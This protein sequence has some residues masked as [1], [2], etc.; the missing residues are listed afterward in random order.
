MLALKRLMHQG[1]IAVSSR[2]AVVS[3]QPVMDIAIDLWPAACSYDGDAF[4]EV[5]SGAKQNQARIQMNPNEKALNKII[6]MLMQDGNEDA[7]TR[8][9]N[10]YYSET[11][12]LFNRAE[13]RDGGYEEPAG[14]LR[15]L[16]HLYTAVRPMA[17]QGE[18]QEAATPEGMESRLL[19]FQRKALAW[20]LARE[21]EVSE[22]EVHPQWVEML[23]PGGETLYS[24]VVLP[25]LL[26]T[27]RF[28]APAMEAG[29]IL[30]E[31]MGLGEFPNRSLTVP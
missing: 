15:S 22:D 21:R 14:D 13:G 30:A 1:W 20:M 2:A 16:E 3:G 9:P 23:L 8:L 27:R 12:C 26:S 6:E 4:V 11:P 19:P 10:T 7:P 25:G 5:Q 17:L 24:H 18:L 31:E 29:G 28:T